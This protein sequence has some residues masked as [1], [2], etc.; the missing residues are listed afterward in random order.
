MNTPPLLAA[1]VLLF[2]GWQTGHVLIGLIAG[3]LLE[4]SRIIKTRWSLT[5]ADFNR[6]WNGCCG[7]F[8]GGAV[9]LFINENPVSIND[10][11]VNA[12]RRPEAIREA[13]RAT[14]VWFQWFPIIFL[15]FLIAQVFNEESKVG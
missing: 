10:F 4:S 11:F 5:Q 7:L 3:A 1:A 14:L 15:P 12:G 9:F 8:F 6:L 13:G 2:W